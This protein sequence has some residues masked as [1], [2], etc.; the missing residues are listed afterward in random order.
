MFSRFFIDRP[1]FAGVIS[2]VIALTGLLTIFLLPIAQFPD[3]VPPT[4]NV[5]AT[6]PGANSTELANTVT[7]PIEIQVNG[8][9]DMIYMSSSSSNDGSLSMNVTFEVG[10][11][12]DIATVN[13]NNRVQQ[14]MPVLPDEVQRQGVTVQKKSTSLVMVVALYDPNAKTNPESAKTPLYLCNYAMIYVRDVLARVPG[15][16]LAKVFDER[17]FGMRVWLDPKILAER[18]ISVQDIISVI[19][20]QNVQ[21]A[22][23]TIG[24]T[25]SPDNQKTE[26]V[27]TALGRLENIEDF[28][29][30]TVR[31]DSEGR[32][33][34]LKDIGRIEMGAQ[35]YTPE[36]FYNDQPASIIGIYQ[37]PGS[38]ALDV[39]NGVYAALRDMENDF[40]RNG[41]A[42]AVSHD[43]TRFVVSSIREVCVTLA[44]AILLVIITVFIFLQDW[45]AVLI[46]TLA[47][48]VSLLGAF[49]LMMAFGYSINTLS[50]FGVVLAIGIVVDDAIIV[51]ENCR[52]LIDTEGLSA[53]DAACKTMLQV[54]G[55]VVATALVLMAVFVP[56]GFMPGIVGR[57][58][59]QFSLTIAGATGISAICALTLSPALCGLL[60]RPSRK[61]KFFFFRW[62]NSFFSAFSQGYLAGV[63]KL[64]RMAAVILLLWVGLIAGVGYTG[65]HLPTGFLPNED[66]AVIYADVHLPDGASFNRTKAFTK[67]L[68]DDLLLGVDGVENVVVVNGNSMINNVQSSNSAMFII[69]LKEWEFRKK[70]GLDADSIARRLTASMDD[71]PG[72]IT[73]YFNPPP[74]MGLGTSGGMQLELLDKAY[75]GN[76]PLYE[77]AGQV[78][79]TAMQSGYFSS[80]TGAF[81][82]AAPMYYLDIDRDKAQKLQVSLQELFSTLQGYFGS[83]YINDFNRFE[84]V[85]KV[86]VMADKD[87]RAVERDLTNIKVRNNNGDMVPIRSFVKSRMVVGPDIVYR[88]NMYPSTLITSQTA[89]GVSTGQCMNA[90][91]EAC[92]DIH[93]GFGFSWTDT[94]Y[95]E[96]KVGH[97]AIII[98]GLATVFAFLVLAAQYESWSAPLIIMMAVPLA[99]AGAFL[100]IMVRGLDFN[101]YT[102]IGLVILIGL[103]A[104]NSILIVEFAR[105]AN[106]EGKSA[107]DSALEAS[108]LRLRP[109]LMTSFAFILGVLPLVVATGAGAIS[110]QAIGTTVFFGMLAVTCGGI[111][112]TPSFYLLVQSIVDKLGR[113]T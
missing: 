29:E 94:S 98:F 67:K 39:A 59:A 7:I 89:A 35:T 19:E 58:F 9:D 32:I 75:Y 62:F 70:T 11:N 83:Y 3:I 91:E 110:R 105:D 31:V 38:N 60:L 46:P 18:G 22:A 25:P 1:I 55:P 71:F 82:P 79:E 48:P 27:V 8:V 33:L 111:F 69:A 84:H 10:T 4:V 87:Y 52:R 90:L 20:E 28:A 102:Q 108:R 107:Y 41:V 103:S 12:P 6:Y 64:L 73:F 16:G 57:L 101:I 13:V 68:T 81:H 5:T 93:G 17:D 63:G 47:I 43:M 74:I 66:Q 106:K 96:K 56:T 30:M 80:I 77:A 78:Q 97:S 42:Y 88:Y 61:N 23:G 92:G 40:D 50:L 36:S 99:V 65:K 49:A 53:R 24:Q 2:L 21:V 26:I 51:V 14:A 95:Q 76:V 85:F 34:K 86:M 44:I 72:A 104:K 54:Q 15:V 45:R 37:L 112:I 100:G 113:K 109:I